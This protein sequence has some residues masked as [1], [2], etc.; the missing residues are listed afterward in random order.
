MSRLFFN[1]L[2]LASAF[3]T[4]GC[5][6]LP[7]RFAEVQIG[8]SRDRVE[9]IMGPPSHYEN[10]SVSRSVAMAVYMSGGY[11]C[12]VRYKHDRVVARDCMEDPDNPPSKGINWAGALSALGSGLQTSSQASLR[13]PA[14]NV[15]VPS[16]PALAEC[17]IRP[18]PQ[19]G[20]EPVCINGRWIQSCK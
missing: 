20:C 10:I 13:T 7:Q 8:D 1:H 14:E 15:Y 12:G 6:T 4:G 11:G 16:R 9:E 2:M 5:S 3:I 17:G 19:I 18:I